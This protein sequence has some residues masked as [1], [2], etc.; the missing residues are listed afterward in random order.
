MSEERR[1]GG[2]GGSFLMLLAARLTTAGSGLTSGSVHGRAKTS[3]DA[4]LWV[5]L[6][7]SI[8]AW[9]VRAWMTGAQAL[10]Q[11]DR[12][13]MEGWRGALFE[14]SDSGA[15]ASDVL[16][17][18]G[19]G[20][21]FLLPLLVVAVLVSLFW[22]GVFA[23]LRKRSVDA[24]WLLV[25]WLYVLLLPAD[26]PPVLAALGMSFGCIIGLQVFG[27]TGYYVASPAAVGVLFVQFSY[28]GAAELTL[29]SGWSSALAADAGSAGIAMFV[30]SAAGALVML[31]AGI[32]SPGTLLGAV[33]SIVLAV[34][35]S[36][37]GDSATPGP[38]A[39][40][41]LTLGALPVCLAFVLTDPTTAPLTRSGR[42]LHG[43]LFGLLVVAIRVLDPE[44]PDG[45]LFAVLTAGLCVPLLDYIVLRRHVRRSGGR[46][47]IRA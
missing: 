21:S 29:E 27:G 35:I 25:P 34:V 44:H 45:S 11:T 26:L 42:W 20:A 7:A 37:A 23:T 6:L 47:E 2:P 32:S 40:A 22:A 14:P 8:P 46:L 4:V 19:V 16:L 10:G 13:L 18:I 17:A 3:I 15:A 1:P 31:R 24:G 41:H 12:G 33:A 36:G 5:I 43:A 9:C 38:G 30:A 39:L 28:P